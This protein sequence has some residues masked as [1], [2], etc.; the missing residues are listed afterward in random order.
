MDHSQHL[1]SPMEGSQDLEQCST[2]AACF[3]HLFISGNLY[4]NPGQLINKELLQVLFLQIFVGSIPAI[5]F[6]ATQIGKKYNS[7]ENDMSP[8][9]HASR[10]ILEYKCFE[11]DK[12]VQHITCNRLNYKYF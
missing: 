4:L 3:G 2:A 5:S 12:V 10:K 6:F 7:E 9:Y 11:T 8:N 1:A